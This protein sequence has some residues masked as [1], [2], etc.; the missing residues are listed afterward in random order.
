VVDD[1]DVNRAGLCVV[2]DASPDITVVAALK[3]REA[4]AERTLWSD[5]DIVIIDPADHRREGDQFPGVAVVREIRTTRQPGELI[6][7]VI[8]GH[9]FDDALRRRMREA[10]AD[11]FHHRAD[12]ADAGRFREL[13]V[14]ANRT[15]GNLPAPTDPEALIKLGV[16]NFTRVNRAVKYA[17]EMELESELRRREEPR[18]RRWLH[19]RHRFNAEARLT[20]MTSDGRLPDRRQDVPSLP[21]I[22]RFL[23]WAMKI[24]SGAVSTDEPFRRPDDELPRKGSGMG[25]RL[26]TRVFR[27]HD[28]LEVAAACC[29][30]ADLH[31]RWSGQVAVDDGQE[32]VDVERL[33]DRLGGSVGEQLVD[34]VA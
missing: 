19:F 15:H 4:L 32:L 16:T 5:V 1:D 28:W 14:N 18:S 29:G 31:S 9:Y 7:I 21:Q 11:Y 27:D 33:G 26:L 8:T 34:D 24:K 13:V 30:G 17:L 6:I 20:P 3:N 12:A 2:L 25:G 23:Q 10:R 22:A